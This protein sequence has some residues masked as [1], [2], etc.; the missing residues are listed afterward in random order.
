MEARILDTRTRFVNF[1]VKMDVNL[2][3]VKPPL[4]KRLS[5]NVREVV[6]RNTRMVLILVDG[7]STVADL[8]QKTGNAQLVN[9]A[10]GSRARRPDRPKLEQDS[11]WE[12][13]RKLAEEIRLLR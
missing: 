12:Q 4:V 11:V 10:A 5:G 13:S 6:Q 8:C 2:I 7:T 9:C 1:S 3:Y